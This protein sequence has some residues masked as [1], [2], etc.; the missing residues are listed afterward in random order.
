MIKLSADQSSCQ[1]KHVTISVGQNIDF[2]SCTE[3]RT[4]IGTILKFKQVNEESVW[5][6]IQDIG[7]GKK[8]TTEWISCCLWKDHCERGLFGRKYLLEPKKQ[9]E[10]DSSVKPPTPDGLPF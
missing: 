4:S 7:N 10:H 6:L 8:T 1:I 9:Q 3:T 5:M 2:K